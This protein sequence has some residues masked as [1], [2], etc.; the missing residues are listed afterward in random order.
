[1]VSACCACEK[2]VELEDVEGEVVIMSRLGRD[3]GSGE[4]CHHPPTQKIWN[5]LPF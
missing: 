2:E 5:D 3:G 1:M 4:G